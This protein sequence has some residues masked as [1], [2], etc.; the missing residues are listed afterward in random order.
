[1][2]ELLNLSEPCFLNPE[3]WDVNIL[4]SQDWE[5]SELMDVQALDK[6]STSF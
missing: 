2:D 6:L 3:N 4:T 5:T 1:M